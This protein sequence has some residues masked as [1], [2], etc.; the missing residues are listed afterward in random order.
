MRLPADSLPFFSSGNPLR[1]PVR[2][3]PLPRSG[4]CPTVPRP[5]ASG[6]CS[7]CK[8]R[9]YWGPSYRALLSSVLFFARPCGHRSHFLD[10]CFQVLF[11][12]GHI[13]L[14]MSSRWSAGSAARRRNRPKQNKPPLY[15]RVQRR[16]ARGRKD[17]VICSGLRLLFSS[18]FAPVKETFDEM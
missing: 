18:A 13:S 15:D 1:R 6:G 4:S 2:R 11:V 16:A 5:A 9:K 3:T 10:P 7:G 17:A 12:T 8:R 14:P